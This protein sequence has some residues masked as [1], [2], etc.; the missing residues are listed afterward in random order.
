MHNLTK[1]NLTADI[2]FR[3][4]LSPE[5]AIETEKKLNDM[6]VQLGWITPE[7]AAYGFTGD[8]I[9]TDIS[10]PVEHPLLMTEAAFR[11]AQ[12]RA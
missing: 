4:L 12:C 11:G 8:T 1:T 10:T 3:S 6:F 7:E 9:E 5:E 2:E